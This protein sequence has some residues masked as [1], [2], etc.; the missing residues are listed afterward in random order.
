MQRF[1][2]LL[3]SWLPVEI[4]A[5]V[6]G[7]AVYTATTG[8]F[9]L[10][11]VIAFA[12]GAYLWRLNAISIGTVYLIFH[13]T[14]LLRQPIELIR[15][16]I[17]DLQRAEASIARVRD[18]LAV[19]SKLRVGTETSLS[20]GP[21]SVTFKEVSFGYH[22]GKKVLHGINFNLQPGQV[23]GLLGHT[24][25]GKTTLA[26]LA[27]RLYDPNCGEIRLSGVQLPDI[28]PDIFRRHV[29]M[30]TQEVQLFQASVRDNLTFF[31]SSIPD[32]QL[33]AILDDLGLGL[34]YQALPAGL[35]TELK[36]G[37][38]N[39]SAGQ[40]QLPAFARVFL[41]NFDDLS[42]A[43]DVET[44]HQLWERTFACGDMTCLVVS[45]R[46]VALRR[47]DQI[48]VLKHG[49]VEAIGTLDRLLEENEEMQRLWV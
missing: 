7:D 29:R 8:L 28:S 40:A 35:D 38:R 32:D 17:D 24:G 46:R 18:L 31:N 37:G 10:G 44:E 2:Q 20:S 27:L 33:I 48:V 6:M 30:V 16:Q 21:L 34:W 11:H 39:L 45:H 22:E 36:S 25:S 43:L 47:A 3:R 15:N 5:N 49:N 42:S 23:L 19:R 26:H 9:L 14:E 41:A 4:K 12:L 13:Y 1:Y